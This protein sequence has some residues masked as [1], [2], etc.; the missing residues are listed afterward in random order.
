MDREPVSNLSLNNSRSISYISNINNY[1][2]D[3]ISHNQGNLVEILRNVRQDNNNNIIVENSM[4]S[5]EMAQNS[6]SRQINLVYSIETNSS[7]IH[8][9]SREYFGEESVFSNNN[10]NQPSNSN[11]TNEEQ[12]FD[13]PEYL[14]LKNA[15]AS[16]APARPINEVEEFKW[17]TQFVNL[18]KAVLY[19]NRLIQLKQDS[20]FDVDSEEGC[21]YCKRF[22]EHLEKL[23]KVNLFLIKVIKNPYCQ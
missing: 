16:T 22:L 11:L 10:N 13:D 15:R 6:E 5:I 9:S 7:S 20:K 18:E 19:S 12:F 8:S 21:Q 14:L 23:I 17:S 2:N 4:E 1:I 3:S